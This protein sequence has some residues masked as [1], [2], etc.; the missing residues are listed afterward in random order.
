MEFNKKENTFYYLPKRL[1]TIRVL[2]IFVKNKYG[3]QKNE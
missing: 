2:I 3:T 1:N